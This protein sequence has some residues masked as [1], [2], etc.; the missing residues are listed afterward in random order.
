L[1]SVVERARTRVSVGL[2]T[3]VLAACTAIILFKLISLIKYTDSYCDQG[4]YLYAAQR[5][6]SG[7]QISGS[8]L[9]ETNP[10]LILWF[11][12][13]PVLLGHLVHSDPFLML[14]LMVFAMIGASTAWSTRILR[15]A[16]VVDSLAILYAG[17]ASILG[18]EIFLKGWVF[19]ER[20][21]FLVILILPYIFS[22]ICGATSNLHFVERCLL[23]I[24]AGVAVCFKPQHAVILIAFELFLAIWNRSLR[25]LVGP[26]LFSAALAVL[27]Y[28]IVARLAAPLYFTATLP[29]LKETYWAFGWMDIRGLIKSESYF[30]LFFCLAVVTFDLTRLEVHFAIAP[31][32]FWP[33][34][35]LRRSRSTS[36]IQGEPIEPIRKMPFSF[37]Q[38][39]GLQLRAYRRPSLQRGDS[40]LDSPPPR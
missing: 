19:A 2:L 11:S 24:A 31:A 12:T 22:A 29:L 39:V 9:V 6:L 33:A 20:E 16:D 34:P 21:H 4:W 10:P 15:S 5:V 40:A 3:F 35:R 14:K 28:V 27:V 36:N 18:A 25:R 32:A 17:A 23:G 13:I 8:Q 26:D 7:A 38:F 37:L 30:V 1:T